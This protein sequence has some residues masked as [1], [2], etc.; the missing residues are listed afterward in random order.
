MT[1]G[2][3][4]NEEKRT[5]KAER[6]TVRNLER[7]MCRE[8]QG[9]IHI[10]PEPRTKTKVI[11]EVHIPGTQNILNLIWSVTFSFSIFFYLPI[12]Q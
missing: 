1:I 3:S 11:T 2:C 9:D 5:K 10:A 7:E 4:Y 12:Y 8:K 6:K